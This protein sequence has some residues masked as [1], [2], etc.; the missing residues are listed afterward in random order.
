MMAAAS[1]A[2]PDLS[3]SE[4]FLSFQGEGPS[5]GERAV[6]LRLAGCNLSCTWCDTAYAWDWS[7]HDRRVSTRKAAAADAAD[8]L[9]GLA[10]PHCR[11]LVLTGGEPLLQ[12][13]AAAAVLAR[14]RALRPDMR[15]EVETNGTVAP[16]AQMARLVHRFVVSPKLAHAGLPAPARLDADALRSFADLDRSV[17]KI[18]AMGPEDLAEAASIAASAGFSPDRVWIMPLGTSADGTLDVARALAE[19]VLQAGYNLS[20]R[21]HLLLWGDERGK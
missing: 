15:C 18:V 12:Q 4:T 1:T 11:L 21:Q 5:A 16:S 20:L 13:R 2:A 14:V 6:F 9:A 8:Q 3:V 19:L 17:L 7:R 10:G